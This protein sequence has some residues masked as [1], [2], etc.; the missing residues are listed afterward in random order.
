MWL[1]QFKISDVFNCLKMIS[2]TVVWYF[3]FLIHTI[4]K[5]H[6][7]IWIGLQQKSSTLSH[8]YIQFLNLYEVYVDYNQLKISLDDR[9]TKL[10]KK[11]HQLKLYLWCFYIT[12]FYVSL[13]IKIEANIMILCNRVRH[14]RLNLQVNELLCL[15]QQ[16]VVKSLKMLVLSVSS[17]LIWFTCNVIGFRQNVR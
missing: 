17:R 1:K 9:V 10:Q 16:D 7:Y 11:S 2:Y 6:W 15:R 8:R 13:I 5:S 12:L 14:K 4:S 3:T